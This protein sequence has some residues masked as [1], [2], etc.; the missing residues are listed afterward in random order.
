M[1]KSKTKQQLLL[2][3]EELQTCLNEAEETL[4]AIRSGEADALIVPGPKGEQVYTLQGADRSYRILLQTM[5]EGAAVL[6]TDGTILYC[7]QRLADMLKA[8]LE[9]VTDSSIKDYFSPA[10]WQRFRELL[11]E[12]N[13]VGRSEFD[14]HTLEGNHVPTL[15]SLGSLPGTGMPGF[16]LIAADL[17]EQKR[18]EE[19]LRI[20]H[21]EL[22]ERVKERTKELR[23]EIEDRER[24]EER[25]RESEARFRVAADGSLDAFFILRSVRD[26]TG[27]ITDFEF[28][29]LNARAERLIAMPKEKAIGQ[30]LCELIPI[31][32]ADG[33]F[34]KYVRVVETGE[35]LDEECP[36]APGQIQASWIRHQVIP[37]ADGVAITSRDITARKGAEEKIKE[38]NEDLR[39]RA[40]EVEAFN[41]QLEAVNKELESFSYSVSHDLR[42]P[43]RGID[44]FSQALL[45][46]YSEK[47]DESGRDFLQRIRASTQRMGQL[48]DDMLNLSR[49]TRSEMRRE[50]VD[51]SALADRIVKDLQ[52]KQPERQVEFLIAP[53]L[54]TDGD[55]QLLKV[56]LENLL[57][58]AWKFTGKHSPARIEFGATKVQGKL[59]YFVRDDG[60]GFDMTYA[61]K[62]FIPFQ[63]LHPL[64]DFPGTGIGLA[65][66]RRIIQK[67]GGGVWAEGKV[68]KGATFYF[69]LPDKGKE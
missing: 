2:D 41:R 69:T 38:L 21:A 14:L 29:E 32:R 45:E 34:D 64:T 13:G 47:L 7:N 48:I 10:D 19:A 65:T 35:L 24:A 67:H 39:K 33:F 62:L 22:E 37:L 63:R 61:G 50:G 6:D 46:D 42:A 57:G 51:L 5:G 54:M 31:N 20:A 16:C 53:G 4:R 49:V 58:N 23:K 25:L 15:L 40:I 12:G 9:K 60:T 26:R 52:E 56:A 36:I 11:K 55:A 27:R 1:D 66:V 17:T 8:P 18:V 44:G 43:L 68:G 30:K 28:V 3:I 59:A